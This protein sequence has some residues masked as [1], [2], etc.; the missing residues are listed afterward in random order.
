M[1]SVVCLSVFSFFS[2]SSN[3]LIGTFLPLTLTASSSR[4][5]NS[6]LTSVCVVSLT[7]MFTPYC[8]VIPSRRDARLTLS[9]MAV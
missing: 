5:V 2:M 3:I 6:F 9:P 1:F 7:M 8:L 4:H